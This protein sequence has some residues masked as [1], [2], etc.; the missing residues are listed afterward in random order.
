MVHPK[1]LIGVATG[2]TGRYRIFDIA[3]ASVTKPECSDI[4]W[5]MGVNVPGNFNNI[6]R[7]TLSKDY[8]WVWILGDDHY[9]PKN[10]LMNLLDRNV[11]IV[12]PLYTRRHKPFY[13]MIHD[14]IDNGMAVKDWDFL[15]GKQGLIEL[16]DNN[17]GNAGMLIRRKVIEYMKYP[18]FENGKYNSETGCDLWFCEKAKKLGF[19]L[20]LD[21]D[22][23]LGHIVNSVVW[24]KNDNGEWTYD[25][26]TI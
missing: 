25:I 10:L 2:E 24:P 17:I 22:N 20:Y 3:L 15:E 7:E 12:A 9:F 6:I 16:P 1:G 11:D 14:S 18:W 5:G 13:P 21:L 23:T 4:Y 19:K 8:D 26:V